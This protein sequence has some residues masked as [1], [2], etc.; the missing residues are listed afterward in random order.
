MMMVITHCFKCRK[1]INT[2]NQIYYVYIGK[3]STEGN[4][5]YC[6]DCYLQDVK[7]M[8]ELDPFLTPI[9]ARNFIRMNK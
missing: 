1:D 4:V 3:S 2:D 5:E 7:D 8:S 6:I 9:Y